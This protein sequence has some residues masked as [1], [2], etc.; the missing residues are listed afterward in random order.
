MREIHY[1]YHTVY[2]K[3][4]SDAVDVLNESNCDMDIYPMSGGTKYSH[5]DD[6]ER[7]VVEEV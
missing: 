2:A 4:G 5:T 1:T 6:V 3:S 7:W